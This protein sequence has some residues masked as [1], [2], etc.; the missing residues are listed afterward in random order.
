MQFVDV[1]IRQAHPGPGAR[2]YRTVEAKMQDGERYQQYEGFPWPVLVDDLAGT[3]HQVYSGL[4]D[5]TYLIDAEGRVA[6]FSMWT[7]VSGIYQAIQEVLDAGGR[8]VVKGGWDRMPHLAPSMTDGWRGL[9]LGLP[10]SVID[11]TLASPGMASSTWLGY[12]LRPLLAPLTLR[13]RPLPIVVKLALAAGAAI[14]LA[15]AIGRA[16]RSPGH[17]TSD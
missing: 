5:P 10:Q 4:V 15:I 13:A 3:V 16:V 11:L 8:G 7:G 17:R 6:Y 14:P 9:R 12:Q 2:P 1:L